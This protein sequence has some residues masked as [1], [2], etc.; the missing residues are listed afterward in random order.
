MGGCETTPPTHAPPGEPTQRLRRAPPGCG[1][2]FWAD[3]PAFDLRHHVRP[4]P[5]PPPGDERAL[6]E[7][8]AA[9]TG[10]PLP[11]SRPLWS[12]AFVTG[13]AGGSTGLVIVMNHVLADGIGGLAVLARLVDGIP[14]LPPGHPERTRFPVPAPSAR[15]LAA[16]A[17]AGRARSLA[18]P[19][20]SLRT[21]QQGLAELGGT[22]PPRTLPPTSLNRPTG[23]QRR[24]DVVAAD[25]AAVRDLGHAH[26]GTVNDVILAAIAG[27]LR[28][29]LASR[30]EQLDLV[31]ASVPVS[32]RPAATGGQLGNQVGVMPVLMVGRDRPAQRALAL[33]GV[34]DVALLGSSEAAFTAG[35]VSFLAGHVAWIIALRQRP[36]GGRLRARPALAVPHVTAFGALNAYLWQRTGKDRIPVIVYSAALLAMSLVALDSGS[37]KTAA[38][39]AL[40]LVSDALLALEKFGGLHLPANEGLVM[41]AYT[42]AQA[43]LAG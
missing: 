25:L 11:R 41:A 17:W 36:G 34:G 26:G 13:L 23:P 40:F 5:C 37:P 2:P 1:R 19:A 14:G 4:R 30:G 12:A 28:A 35:L 10:E 8:A 16:D 7:V 31:T 38:G 22:R 33:G 3:D 27:A 39:G 43:L 32:A 15:T 18:H 21:I 29:L 9:V 42:S 24:L 6:L 20:R